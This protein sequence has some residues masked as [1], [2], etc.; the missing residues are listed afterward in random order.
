LLKPGGRLVYATCSIL[1]SEN[2]D[3]VAA[4]LAR[5]PALMPEH[6]AQAWQA[7]VA[8]PP[9]PGLAADF[10]ATPFQTGTDGFYTA[11]LRWA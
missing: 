11:L 4:L 7:S 5:N 3:R 2:Q 8:S 10:R 6:A 1:P 9:P